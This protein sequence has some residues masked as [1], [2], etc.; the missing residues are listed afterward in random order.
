MVIALK[1]I[2]DTSR[3]VKTEDLHKKRKD[4]AV[5]FHRVAGNVQI[6]AA[7]KSTSVQ[8]LVW[9]DENGNKFYDLELPK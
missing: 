4:G 3:D 5:R 8:I 9:E 7:K 1:K 6:G 2:L